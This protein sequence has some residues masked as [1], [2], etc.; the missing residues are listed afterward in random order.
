MPDK[1]VRPRS[2]RFAVNP[3]RNFKGPCNPLE[4]GKYYAHVYQTKVEVNNSKRTL[5]SKR[6]AI[7][8]KRIFG[9]RYNPRPGDLSVRREEFKEW[10]NTNNSQMNFQPPR[11]WVPIAQ[12][13]DIKPLAHERFIWDRPDLNNNQTNTRVHSINPNIVTN[14]QSYNKQMLLNPGDH[15]NQQVRYQSHFLPS[16]QAPQ[17]NPRSYKQVLTNQQGPIHQQCYPSLYLPTQHFNGAQ[18][19]QPHFR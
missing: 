13:Q 11:Q 12:L 19:T 8:L 9:D 3:P 14:T 15:R 7:E 18:K 1:R 2:H 10:T 16:N 4:V 17:R 5:R 6:M